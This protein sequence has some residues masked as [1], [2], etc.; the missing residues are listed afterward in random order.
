MVMPGPAQT[1]AP[2]V[3]STQ[4]LTHIEGQSTPIT[5][6]VSL[7]NVPNPKTLRHRHHQNNH[8]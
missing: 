7:E 6:T 5:F 3:L 2:W 1:A 8:T 4:M